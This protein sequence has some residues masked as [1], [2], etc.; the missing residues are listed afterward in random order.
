MALGVD[1][2]IRGM[3]GGGSQQRLR[4]ILGDLVVLWVGVKCDREIV[5]ARKA[6]RLDRVPGMAAYQAARV[7]EGVVY[8]V[9]VDT[10]DS[11][12]ESCASTIL[13][14]ESTLG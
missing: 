4:P 7:H 6:M 9:V 14:R 3:P 11:S 5:R 10:S 13:S 12:S 8:D 1:D 2:L